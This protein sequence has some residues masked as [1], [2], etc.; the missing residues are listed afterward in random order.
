MG[1]FISSSKESYKKYDIH[2]QF[3]NCKISNKLY[4][5]NSSKFPRHNDIFKVKIVSF[6]C[7]I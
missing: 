1:T 5:R 3:L 6:L 4:V 2:T 7:L